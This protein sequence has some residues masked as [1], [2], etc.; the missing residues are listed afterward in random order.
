MR[1]NQVDLKETPALCVSFWLAFTMRIQRIDIAVLS[2]RKIRILALLSVVSMTTCTDAAN[3]IPTALNG[4]LE[5]NCLDCHD[6]SVTK[7]DLNIAD[8]KFDLHGHGGFATWKRIYEK[9]T[10]DEMPPAKKKRPDSSQRQDFLNLLE[11]RLL[12]TDRTDKIAKGRVNVR[13]LTRREYE[14]TIHDLLGVDMPVDEMLPED[15]ATHGFETV[16]EGQQLSHHNLRSY[17]ETADRVLNHAFERATVG[18]RDM[19]LRLSPRHMARRR[20]GNYRGPQQVGDA[21]HFWPITLQFYGR[22][23]MSQVRRSGW[24]RITLKNVRS[25]NPQSDSVWGTLRSGACNS[26]TPMLY[27]VGLVEATREKRD[28]TFTAWIRGGHMLEFKPNDASQ[29]RAR[30][31]ARGGNVGYDNNR[32]MFKERVSGIEISGIEIE[33]FY[34]NST[35]DELRQKLFGGIAKADVERL[36]DDPQNRSIY[37]KVITTFAN[38]A[39][40][41]PTTKEQCRPYVDLALA[42]L[43]DSQHSPKDAIRFAYRAILCS[44][45][46]LTFIEKPG[47]LDHHALASRLSYALWNSMPDDQLRQLADE[48]KLGDSKVFHAEIKRMIDDPRSDRFIESFADQWLNLKEIDFTQPDLRM[49][50]T[51]DQ[52]VKSSMLEETRAFLKDLIVRNGPI[53]NIIHSDYAMLN[54]RLVRFYNMK[55]V[56][57]KPGAGM[58]RVSLNGHPRGGLITQG[59]VLKVTANGTTTSPVVRGVWVSERILG[60]EIPPPPADVPAV[61]PDIR[62]AVSIRDQLDKHRNNESCAS[63]HRNIDPAGFALENFDPVGLI[64]TRY[65]SRSS[66]ARVDPSGVTP[67]G[68]EFAGIR[69]WKEIYVKRTELLTRAFAKHLLTYATGAAPRFSDHAELDAI[70]DQSR[71]SGFGMRSILNVALK[72]DI[73]RTK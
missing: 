39:F 25:V 24:Y 11:A 67:E 21:S 14:Y 38:R 6:D 54:E 55:Q 43:Q 31:G 48:G 49:Y 58:Q 65:G 61:E 63:C 71:E 56:E 17:L 27:P 18:E 42:T 22:M 51:F 4:F 44:P 59:S 70:V 62:G 1:L 23:P 10:A 16:A 53:Q 47:S 68:E 37:E 64:R 12:T 7:G 72:S 60:L 46:F 52:V 69:E 66:S 32:S 29:R 40:R 26:S 45:R 13:R 34:P 28:R 9:V 8:L 41:R 30:T 20:G 19:R 3:A 73:F 57:L 35:R 5:Q 50:R 2:F 15:P 33:R 36:Q